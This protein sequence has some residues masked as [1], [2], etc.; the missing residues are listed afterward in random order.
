MSRIRVVIILVAALAVLLTASIYYLNIMDYITPAAP[1]PTKQFTINNIPFTV[2]VAS[3]SLDQARGLSG[4]KEL[5]P[6]HGMMFVFSEPDV[7]EFWMKDMNFPLDF[8]WIRNKT[9]VQLDSNIPAPV[10]NS[11]TPA[12]VSPK[13]PID[14]VIEIS[15][16]WL[17]KNSIKVGDRLEELTK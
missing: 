8:I 14:T 6:N 10:D 16:G 7:Y 13:Q 1:L 12:R 11:E 5:L 17:A 3:K 4:R 15:A 2:E 9:V